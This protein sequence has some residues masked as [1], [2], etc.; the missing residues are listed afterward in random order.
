MLNNTIKR[1][2]DSCYKSLTRWTYNMIYKLIFATQKFGK[3]ILFFY[4]QCPRSRSSPNLIYMS[5]ALI[6]HVI[7][8]GLFINCIC[9]QGC[10]DYVDKANSMSKENPKSDNYK[11]HLKIRFDKLYLEWQEYMSQFEVRLSSLSS[12]YINC[13]PY[14]EIMQM[15]ESALPL[16]FEKMEEG[17]LTDWKERQYYLWYAVRSITGVDL[18][19]KGMLLGETEIAKKYILWWKENQGTRGSN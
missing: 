14:N 16:I 2:I 8:I 11:E 18:K 15:G 13:R 9:L 19:E 10:I 1:T 17:T 6:K 7:I 3:E 5:K 4:L 12:D